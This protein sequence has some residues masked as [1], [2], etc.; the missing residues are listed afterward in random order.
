[1]AVTYTPQAATDGLLYSNKIAEGVI[2]SAIEDGLSL[3][4]HPAIVMADDVLPPGWHIG[5]TP[6]GTITLPI[7]MVTPLMAST[8][9]TTD[10]VSPTTIDLTSVTMSTGAY[11]LC[12]GVSN[13]LR[14]RDQHGRYQVVRIASDITRSAVLT[15]TSLICAL[16]PSASTTVGTTGT[17]LTWDVIVS[18]AADIRASG[19]NQ[20]AGPVVVILHPA[21]WKAVTED[22]ASVGG[23][24][25]QRREFDAFQTSAMVGYQGMVDDIEVW[26]CDRITESGGDYGGLMFVRG[27]IGMAIVPPAEAAPDQTVI[28]QSPLVQVSASYSFA[29]KS[30]QL[31]GDMTVGVSILR[32]ALIREILS[33]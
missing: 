10:M 31:G 32:Q 24:R 6:G 19:L 14:R 28:L 15:I 2:L 5:L 4:G 8:A 25:A 23:A 17:P 7:D 18:A 29:D 30:V 16:A 27:G 13:E 9:E 33:T 22:L 3:L 20:A 11:D 1:M 12:F 21:Q 26:T